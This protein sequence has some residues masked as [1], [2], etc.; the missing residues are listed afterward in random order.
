MLGVR[1]A[2][3]TKYNKFKEYF[4]S[5]F[6]RY[7]SNDRKVVEQPAQADITADNAKLKVIKPIS[8][9]P[10]REILS[11][12][13]ADILVAA[14]CRLRGAALKLG[15]MLSIQDSNVIPAAFTEILSRVRDSA[16]IMP[17]KQLDSMLV[18]E[19]GDWRTIFKWFHTTPL[20]AASIGARE[21]F[22]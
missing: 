6:N 4:R 7:F 12:A 1:L 3:S 20:A 11:N 22:Y 2:F 13:N 15:Q 16:N 18:N 17:R 10:K 19:F 21:L 14:L 8:S 9:Q 5:K